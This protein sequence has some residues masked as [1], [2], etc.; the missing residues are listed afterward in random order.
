MTQLH[1]AVFGTHN[2]KMWHIRRILMKATH[3]YMN[4]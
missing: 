3:T 2:G 1:K 4:K